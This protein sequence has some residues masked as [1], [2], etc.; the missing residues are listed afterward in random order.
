MKRFAWIGVVSGMLAASVSHGLTVNSGGRGASAPASTPTVNYPANYQAQP[1]FLTTQTTPIVFDISGLTFLNGEATLPSATGGDGT[2]GFS[3]SAS[4]GCTLQGMTLT[5]T[6]ITP[7]S[8]IVTKASDGSFAAATLSSVYVVLVGDILDADAPVFAS[9]APGSLQITSSASGVLGTFLASDVNAITYSLGGPGASSFDLSATLGELTVASGAVLSHTNN[10][11]DLTVTATDSQGNAGTHSL[12]VNVNQPPSVVTAPS[13]QT[14]VEG[15]AIASVDLATLFSDGDGDSLIYGVSGEPTGVTLASGV[16]SGSVASVGT[17]TITLTATDPLGDSVSATFDVIVNG[18]NQAPVVDSAIADQ[19]V[20][21]GD[22]VSLDLSGVFRD[23]DADIL[24]LS[25]AG[26]PAWATFDSVTGL[27]TGTAAAGSSDEVSALTVTANDGSLTASDTFDFTV[28]ATNEI[29]ATLTHWGTACATGERMVLPGDYGAMTEVS[30]NHSGVVNSSNHRR[31][32]FLGSTYQVLNL[33]LTCSDSSVSEADYCV[34]GERET[35]TNYLASTGSERW[36]ALD[37]ISDESGDTLGTC[38]E[39]KYQ[40]SQSR[41]PR[42]E[43]GG[44][45]DSSQVPNPSTLYKLCAAGLPPTSGDS[46]PPF[47]NVTFLAGASAPSSINA[48][49]YTWAGDLESGSTVTMTFDDLYSLNPSLYPN[50][51]TQTFTDT[52]ENNRWTITNTGRSNGIYVASFRAED[53]AGNVAINTARDVF[54]VSHN[55]TTGGNEYGFQQKIPVYEASTPCPEGFRALTGAESATDFPGDDLYIDK[56]VVGDDAASGYIF[57][58][59]NRRELF[60]TCGET[61]FEYCFGVSNSARYSWLRTQPVYTPEANS[62]EY[63]VCYPEAY[64]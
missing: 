7:C 50:N 27:I 6:S 10:P 18:A 52:G 13:D 40:G 21:E 59:S 36:F 48:A 5:A 15:T 30:F 43:L 34:G 57:S 38:L 24:T 25:V 41:R 32:L 33:P 20:N 46:I 61:S 60:R 26:L 64:L 31:Y 44:L 56:R 22:M 58:G 42:Y 45:Y 49:T 54:S 19:S 1:G 29:V 51:R 4:G 11:Y 2:G 63:K 14:I 47:F 35:T 53:S 17:A 37:C 3:Y 16:L 12:T 23:P 55:T 9:S 62:V 28:V 39:A 8:V